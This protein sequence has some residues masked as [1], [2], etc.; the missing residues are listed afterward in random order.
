MRVFVYVV[1]CSITSAEERKLEPAFCE[2]AEVYNFEFSGEQE[3]TVVRLDFD[4]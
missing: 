1:R 3:P 2:G 4:H